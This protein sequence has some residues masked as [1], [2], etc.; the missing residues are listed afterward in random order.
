MYLIFTLVW[1][2]HLFFWIHELGNLHEFHELRKLRESHDL[3]LHESHD[4]ILH[5]SH[6]MNLREFLESDLYDFH[7]SGKL[8]EFHELGAFSCLVTQLLLAIRPLIHDYFGCFPTIFGLF[9]TLR[10]F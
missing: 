3:T 9:Q 5:E 10:C 6:E 4:L 1:N 7:E 2:S 8:H